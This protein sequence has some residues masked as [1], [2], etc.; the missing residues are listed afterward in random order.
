MMSHARN[1]LM[2]LATCLV[3]LGVALAT[4]SASQAALLLDD[5]WADGS[6]AETNLPNESATWVGIPSGGGAVTVSPGALSMTQSGS[7]QKLWTF[8]APDGSPAELQVGQQLRATIE[9]VPKV[10]LYN[11]T[12]R[13]FRMGLFHDPTNSQ[14]QADVNSDGGGSGNPWQD[15]TGYAVL[16]PLTSGPST[17]QQFQI[18]KRTNL[19]NTSLLGSTSA[20]TLATS[21]GGEVTHALDTLY[22]LV[23][24]LDFVSSAQMDIT[25]TLSDNTGILAQQSVSD[26]GATLGAAAPYSLFD[27][28]FFRFSSASG[29][30]DELEFRR[31]RVE[32]IPEP[33]SLL[34]L[35]LGGLALVMARRRGN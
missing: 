1:T 26:D 4:T 18:G 6:R 23:F 17:T 31:F 22:T 12:S 19:A 7:S 10:Q 2:S 15:S 8:F 21:G 33:A 11:T 34:L 16:M 5:T 32:I 25:A 30:A 20:Y 3:A 28:L 29:T 14:I 27:Q 9:F 24:E 35:G 13:N